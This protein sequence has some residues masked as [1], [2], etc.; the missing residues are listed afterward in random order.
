MQ[1]R[2]S[3]AIDRRLEGVAADRYSQ[4]GEVAFVKAAFDVIGATN[5]WCFEVGAS[6]GEEFSNT[7]EFRE[8]GWR[9]CLAE[10]DTS[11]ATKLALSAN[12]KV[13]VRIQEISSI[14][15]WLSETD[16]PRDVDFGSIDVDGRDYW[17]FREMSHF[18]PRV[19]CIEFSPYPNAQH[20][21]EHGEG[22]AAKQPVL[23]LATKKGYTCVAETYVN[24][25]L[26][27]NECLN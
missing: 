26:V 6:D 17:L 20:D 18:R 4:Y 2:C 1:H 24:L 10:S 27:A 23:E 21:P 7:L 9:C 8:S 13:D 14:D 19:L 22:Q 16:C 25:I 3:I 12:A 5:R 11:L 15:S